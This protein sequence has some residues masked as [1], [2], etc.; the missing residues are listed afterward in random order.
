MPFFGF[1]L[2][3]SLIVHKTIFSSS[4]SLSIYFPFLSLS[5]TSFCIVCRRHG[6]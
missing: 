6:I 5:L 1:S 3:H 2:S 4:Y